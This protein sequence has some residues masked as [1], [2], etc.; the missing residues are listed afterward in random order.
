MHHY[1]LVH[2]HTNP[3]EDEDKHKTQ[4][5]KTHSHSHKDDYARVFSTKSF[6]WIPS[7][8]IRY[9]PEILPQYFCIPEDDDDEALANKNQ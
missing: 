7:K 4:K 5:Q 3:H 2:K 8:Y 6:Q 1:I 9:L